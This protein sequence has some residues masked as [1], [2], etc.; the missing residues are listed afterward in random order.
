MEYLID[1]DM[2]TATVEKIEWERIL[3]HLWVRISWKEEAD[4]EEPLEFYLVNGMYAA[5]AYGDIIDIR[6]NVYHIC[7]N[8][9]NNKQ[10][11]C[12]PQ[13]TYSLIVVQGDR[14]MARATTS[15]KIAGH[16]KELSNSFLY[17]NRSKIYSVTFYIEEEEDDLPFVVY[18]LPASKCG[19]GERTPEQIQTR[20]ML[21]SSE[22]SSSG[23]GRLKSK[24]KKMLHKRGIS[25]HGIIKRRYQ[26]AYRKAEHDGKCILFFSEQGETIGTNMKPLKERMIA[27]GMDKEYRIIESYRSVNDHKKDHKYGVKSWLTLVK[28]LGMADI[29]IMEDH[30]PVMDWLQLGP[31]TKV[32]Q[33]WHAGAGFKSSGYSRWGHKGC[34]APNSCHRQYTYG[35][36][37]SR[38]IAHFF[39]EVWGI[40]TSRVLPTGMPRLDEYLN[41][42]HRTEKTKELYEKY[43]MAKGK[44]VILFAPT[45]RGKNKGD[46]HYPY[47]LIDFDRLY[48]VCGEE[49]VV[50]FKM[51]PWVAQPVPIPE[52]YKDRFADLNTYPNI[53]DLFYITDLLIS[54]YSSSI[55]EYSLMRRPML[56]FA[57]DEIQYAYSRG[58]H[59]DYHEAAPGKVVAAFDELLDAIEKK[60]F[61]YEKVE[62]YIE[63]SFD[64]V[65]TGSCDRVIDWLILGNI[66]ED[67]QQAIDADD[68]IAEKLAKLDFTPPDYVW[69]AD[70][71]KSEGDAEE[72]EDSDETDD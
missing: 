41:E 55:F 40:N 48:Q 56:F 57:F 1:R 6:D 67:L 68:A 45:Y 62:E 20:K 11:R 35:I 50:F 59:R 12:I 49:Y 54:D 65:D 37:G 15:T 29:V 18:I 13:G 72:S 22:K 71:E 4:R 47:E 70:V 60:D 26:A 27:R 51:H 24:A 17:K 25:K 42:E 43:P 31:K 69:K 33:L 38:K 28:K 30:A 8:V 5:K 7:M 23:S 46:A 16:L 36:A 34:P 63:N 19:T 21:D 44:K 14:Q 2:M 53:N 64:Y 32:I 58:F 10:N 39:S 3:L 9:T 61:E 66:P 52:K